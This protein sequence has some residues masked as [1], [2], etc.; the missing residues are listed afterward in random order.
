M[1]DKVIGYTLPENPDAIPFRDVVT[2]GHPKLDFITVYRAYESDM[3]NLEEKG[4]PKSKIIWGL[5]IGCNDNG[6]EYFFSDVPLADAKDAAQHVSVYGYAGITTWSLNRD[7]NHRYLQPENE[8]NLLQTGEP[9][10][11]FINVIINEL[12]FK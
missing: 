6:G 11:S 5:A 7:T 4:V 9:D 8:C 1:P 3:Q 12:Q 10:G 2:F